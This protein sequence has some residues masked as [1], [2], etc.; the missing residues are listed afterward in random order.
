MDGRGASGCKQDTGC[1]ARFGNSCGAWNLW[2]IP[3]EPIGMQAILRYSTARAGRVNTAN[4]RLFITACTLST[5]TKPL[6]RVYH[7]T[8]PVT[9]C[10]SAGHALSLSMLY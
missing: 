9:L 8:E 4:R 6:Y 5:N 3:A 2:R 10:L 7:M 1:S